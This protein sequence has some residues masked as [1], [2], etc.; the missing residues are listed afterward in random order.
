MTTWIPTLREDT[1]RYLAIAEALAADM[2]V[3][4]LSPGTKLPTHRDLA[5][6]LGVTVGTVTR[7]YA[8][9]ERRGLVIGEVGRGTF[10]RAQVPD[11]P[12]STDPILRAETREAGILDLSMNLPAPPS[13]P[14]A[15]PDMLAA[16]ATDPAVGALFGYT[17]TLGL[18]EHREVGAAWLSRSGVALDPAR[19]V[20]TMGGQHAMFLACAALTEP[21]DVLLVE[22]ATFYGIKAVAKTLGLRLVGV[23]TDVQGLEPAALDAA[24]RA[25]GGRVL[26]TVPTFQNPTTSVMSQERR[27]EIAEVCRRHGIALIEDD[28]YSFLLDPPPLPLSAHLPELSILFTSLSKCVAPALRVG[29]MAAPEAW[30]ERI[31]LA[32]RATTI[33]PNPLL[34]ETARR[35][36]QD[37]TADRLAAGQRAEAIARQELMQSILGRSNSGATI[38]THPNSFHA[39]LQLPP[40]WRTESFVAAA[41]RRG[42]GVAAGEVFSVGRM[43]GPPAVRICLASAVERSSLEAGLKTL[44]GLLMEEPALEVPLV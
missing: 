5:Y 44:A 40:A 14:E 42:V 26:Y 41:R 37:G 38:V 11:A 4:R 7:A 21:G 31:A 29:W 24:A 2:Q 19:V 28:I 32:G 25:S 30:I 16:V 43:P 9:A 15:V 34:Q 35:L 33:M 13:D 1:P 17:A 36:V 3:G 10:V 12:P 27:E 23:A 18:V 22:E 39:W 6:R 8:E 20:P